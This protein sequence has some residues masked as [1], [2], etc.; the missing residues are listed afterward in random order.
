MQVRKGLAMKCID[1]LIAPIIVVLVSACAQLPQLPANRPF[2]S[3]SA[4][5]STTNLDQALESVEKQHLQA[6]GFRLVADGYEAFA[7]RSASA[8]I[9][10]RSIDVQTY[11]WHP[12]NT[13]AFIVNA[14]LAAADRGVKVRILVD[15]M[16]ARE[17]HLSFSA[18][19]AHPNI[20]V[21]FFNPFSARS[22]TFSKFTEMV[23][24]FERVNR[25]MHNKSWIVD[26][27]IAFVGG[28]NIGDEYFGASDEVNFVDLGLVMVGP[29]VREA[30]DSF[31]RYW[32]S[33]LSYPA[34]LLAPDHVNH[35]S[36]LALRHTLSGLKQSEEAT[37]LADTLRRDPLVEK[38][39]LGNWRLHWTDQFRFLSDEPL[40]AFAADGVSDI[41]GQILAQAKGAKK[42]LWILS[43]YFVP[44]PNGARV[45][46]ELAK[47]G[48]DVRVITNSLASND[49]V[50]AHSGYE[51]YRKR[52]LE[53]G[54]KIWELKP[55]SAKRPRASLFGSSGASL[56]AKAL[57]VDGHNVFVGSYNLDPRS[58]EL[59]T[60]QGVLMRQGTV[61]EQLEALFRVQS[62]AQH[63]WRLELRDDQLHWTDGNIE[64]DS[65][66]EAG[67]G[68]RVMS[69]ILGWLPMERQL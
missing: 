4:P 6:S 37:Q 50:A 14:L 67:I 69:T 41:Y 9:A 18:M 21:R 34:G 56:H 45:I 36:L 27:R 7:L 44:G 51:K 53:A 49:V 22:G 23:A 39:N 19:A 33:S 57:V 58:N 65:E 61:A 64:H 16:D 26:N 30:S 52:L 47:R 8:A 25:R 31:D 46:T 43:P 11:I 66:P 17:E 28:R 1:K 55:I 24:N 38:I 20:S 60:E 40:K 42:A 15:D 29:V 5:G 13:G 32:N 10:D 12:D 54:V 59:N 2:E 63:A 62:D 68:R 48:V 3:V 35:D